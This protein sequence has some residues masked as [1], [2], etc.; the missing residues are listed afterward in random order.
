MDIYHDLTTLLD[1]TTLRNPRASADSLILN[2]SPE[3]IS[4]N[5]SQLQLN[6][7]SNQPS[8]ETIN[9]GLTERDLEKKQVGDWSEFWAALL[10][11]P[12][13]VYKTTY[14]PGA[15]EP[16]RGKVHYERWPRAHVRSLQRFS[17]K[18]EA[19]EKTRAAQEI[20]RGLGFVDS[21]GRGMPKRQD[22]LGGI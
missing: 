11:H 20:L 12:T 9:V 19:E 21:P 4:F 3:G 15:P 2:P 5:R 22:Q 1:S 6:I 10:R 14:Q 16:P 17:T 13:W 8:P 18:K 7:M